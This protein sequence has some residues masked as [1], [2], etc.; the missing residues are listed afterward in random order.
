MWLAQGNT[1]TV[2]DYMASLRGADGRNGADGK[3]GAPGPKGEQGDTGARGPQGPQGPQGP[4][5]VAAIPNAVQTMICIKQNGNSA[6][7]AMG[8]A[9][10]GAA[11]D[12][13]QV[14]IPAA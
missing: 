13:V 10:C 14:Y 6:K 9:N 12:A 11:A 5:G 4:K 8:A 7:L 3:D 2:G 1:G